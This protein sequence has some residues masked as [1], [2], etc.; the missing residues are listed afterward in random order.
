MELFKAMNQW[1]TR[2]T[3]ERF[4]TLGDAHDQCKAYA[5]KSSVVNLPY[6]QLRVE[7]R[8]DG[9]TLVDR[10][11][12]PP[13]EISHYAFGQL[14]Q[15]ANPSPPAGFLRQLPSTL[16][17][18]NLNYGL[19]SRGEDDNANLLLQQVNGGH[20]LRASMS[21]MYS[22]LWNFKIFDRLLELPSGWR[23]PPARPGVADPRARPATA[24]DILQGSGMLSIQV[25][26]MIAP[27]GIYAS[28]HDMFVF[29]VNEDRQIEEGL[30]R[31]FFLWNSE[32]GDTSFGFCSFLYNH[33]CGNHI[34]WGASG[35]VEVRVRHVGKVAQRAFRDLTVEMRK[36]AD[37]SVSD[38]QYTIA[39]AKKLELG[40]SKDQVVAALL[41]IAGK[42]KIIGLNRSTLENSY[43]TADMYQD[44]YGAPNTMWAMVNGLTQHSQE[45]P[46]ADERNRIDRAAGKLLAIAAE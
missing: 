32:V 41:G 39:E 23:V 25:G 21:D 11:G 38:E 44:R 18:Q 17:A 40:A 24:E 10:Q 22:R 29:M 19:K 4:W 35:V 45:T 46:Y 7:A 31:G 2:P 9:M 5:D 8:P 6:S 15:R 12:L 28:D 26:D 27:S 14:C 3:D 13:A 37:S 36:Y 16:A 33:V 30:S 42:K 1:M 20:L 34:V 43:D